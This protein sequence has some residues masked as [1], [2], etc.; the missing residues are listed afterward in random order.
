MAEPTELPE[1]IQRELED[2]LRHAGADKLPSSPRRK[3]GFRL[4]IPDPRPKNP[5]QLVLIG[6]GLFVIAYLLH[7]FTAQLYLASFA[8]VGVALFTYWTY[9]SGHGT[10]LWRGSP[11]S[12]PPSGWQERLYRIVYRGD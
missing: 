9:P 4:S 2:A 6:V 3:R 1:R 5:G 8:C 11:L 7:I 12:L 10:K